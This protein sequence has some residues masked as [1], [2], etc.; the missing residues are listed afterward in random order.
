MERGVMGKDEQGGRMK[1]EGEEKKKVGEG[2]TE[3]QNDGSTGGCNKEG[4]E[5]GSITMNVPWLLG[6]RRGGRRG[7][8]GSLRLGSSGGSDGLFSGLV[9]KGPGCE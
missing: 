8:D 5:Q 1:K 3:G 9:E 6:G 2:R 4:R 7:F